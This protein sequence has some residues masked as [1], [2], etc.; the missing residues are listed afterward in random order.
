MMEHLTLLKLSLC[1]ALVAYVYSYVLTGP[2]MILNGWYNYLDQWIGDAA[3]KPRIWLFK[4][5]I[6]CFTCVA[7]QM[8]LWVYLLAA[9]REYN[10]WQHLVF[11][12]LAIYL[13]SPVHKI[14]T[15]KTN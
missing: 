3:E 15:W 2:G 12:C 1:V 14:Y 10:F 7:G 4:P 8:A 11:V 6:G 9:Y 5:L 13:T